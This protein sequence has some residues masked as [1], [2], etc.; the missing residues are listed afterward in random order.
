MKASKLPSGNWRA[1][2]YITD[3]VTKKQ[4]SKSFTASTRKEA[5]LLALEYE[6]KDPAVLLSKDTTV[7]E[8]IR[9]YIDSRSAVCSPSTLRSY[10]G[11]YKNAY[12]SIGHLS[13][14]DIN[15][16]IIQKWVNSY[17]ETHSPKTTRNA[18]GLLISALTTLNP[19]L[20]LNPTMPQKKIPDRHIPTE[21]QVKEMID[22]AGPTLRKAILLSSIATLRRGE[23]CALTYEDID[24]DTLHVRASMVKNPDG[25]FVTR[26][27]PKTSSSDRYIPVPHKLIE[28][29]GNGEGRIVPLYPDSITQSFNRL[30]DNM[31]LKCRFHDLRHYSASMMHA[32][33]VPDVYIMERGGWSS[34]STLKS[35][36]RNSL[37]D[38]Q[39]K[40]VNL[41]NEKMSELF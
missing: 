21:A 36:Y 26:Q 16:M 40:F 13:M 20:K 9:F 30:R 33:G 38:Q 10:E 28:E 14:P 11:L 35:I 3:P 39:R 1:K 25:K 5:E 34:D 23:I 6:A 18:Y 37:D 2:V 31:G 22:R 19:S 15:Q 32:I 4:T 8:A 12:G 7:S 17:A 27:T 29:L 24:G 41:T